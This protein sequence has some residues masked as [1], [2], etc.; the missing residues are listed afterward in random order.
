MWLVIPTCHKQLHILPRRS[1]TMNSYNIIYI[2]GPGDP[3]LAPDPAV[4]SEA[5]I[6]FIRHLHSNNP[7]WTSAF[8]KI[9]RERLDSVQNCK[10]AG[11]EISLVQVRLFVFRFT[12]GI[13]YTYII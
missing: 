8:N 10:R 4:I 2:L 12:C 1:I 5:L 7:K 13:D 6:E 9:L 3:Y 11:D